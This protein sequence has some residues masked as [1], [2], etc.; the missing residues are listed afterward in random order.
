MSFAVALLGIF[1]AEYSSSKAIGVLHS[2]SELLRPL[3]P[4]REPTQKSYFLRPKTIFVQQTWVI[5]YSRAYHTNQRSAFSSFLWQFPGK[6]ITATM[7]VLLLQPSEWVATIYI[8]TQINSIAVLKKVRYGGESYAYALCP[9]PYALCP[10]E[11]LLLLRK[12]IYANSF[13][14]F[15][16]L[17]SQHRTGYS[18]GVGLT[19]IELNIKNS[20]APIELRSRL[21]CST[22]FV[23]AE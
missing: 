2:I 3:S 13:Y 7:T 8:L 11:H 6:H 10:R 12:A 22:C 20:E 21:C 23:V 15:V 14:I 17:I 18:Y 4:R 9:M 16:W 1:I 19:P 5:F